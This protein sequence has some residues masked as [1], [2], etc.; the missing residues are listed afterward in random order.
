[1]MRFL[2]ITLAAIALAAATLPV[3]AADLSVKAPV[4]PAVSPTYN[5]TGIYLGINGGWAWGSQDPLNIVTDRFDAFSV[6]TSGGLF[7]GT[8]GA[9][10]QVSH[11]VVGVETD[12][13]WANITGSGIVAPRF[14]GTPLGSTVNMSTNMDAIGTARVR[15]GYAMNN[16]LLYATGGLA[17]AEAKTSLT[18]VSGFAC[19]TGGEPFCSGTG[20]KVGGAA[21]GGIEYGFTPNLS[22]K[23]EYLY[24]AVASVEVAHVNEFRAGLNYRFG[25]L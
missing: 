24:L 7:G 19:G 12:I 11:V 5:W 18:T 23:L 10:V 25:G 1:M 8:L 2:S 17:L 14:L 16:V 6:N 13:D 20:R 3:T 22:A 15:A 9:Q 4:M 21:G